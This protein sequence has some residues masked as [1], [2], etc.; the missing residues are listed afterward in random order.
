[1]LSATDC[2]AEPVPLPVRLTLG[3]HKAPELGWHHS[4]HVV[5]SK[6]DPNRLFEQCAFV[7]TDTD[8]LYPAPVNYYLYAHK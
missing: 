7:V 5:L 3:A 4:F 8:Q 1:L 6:K 2:H